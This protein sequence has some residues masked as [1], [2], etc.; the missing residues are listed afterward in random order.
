MGITITD[1]HQRRKNK[2]T[3]ADNASVTGAVIIGL[4]LIGSLWLTGPTGAETAGSQAKQTIV[5]QTH[6]WK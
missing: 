4:L 1:S 2:Q 5:A 3:G 6:Y